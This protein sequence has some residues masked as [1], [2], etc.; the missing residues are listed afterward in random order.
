MLRIDVLSGKM[1]GNH[2]IVR[3]FPFTIGRS[4]SNGLVLEDAGVWDQHLTLSHVGGRFDFA[5]SEG[6]TGLVDGE[7]ARDGRL[8]NGSQLTVGAAILRCGLSETSTGSLTAREWMTWALIIG[9]T[10]FQ[11]VVVYW[12]ARF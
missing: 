9:L 2:Q 4:K 11:I 12:L 6:A 8:K 3:H 7:A 5:Y 10:L 1:A